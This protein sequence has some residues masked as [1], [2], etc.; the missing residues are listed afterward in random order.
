MPTP[1]SSVKLQRKI[2]ITFSLIKIQQQK[3][4]LEMPEGTTEKEEELETS[5]EV[6][7]VVIGSLRHD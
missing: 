3:V 5:P 4:I 1:V 2:E 7:T 6:I